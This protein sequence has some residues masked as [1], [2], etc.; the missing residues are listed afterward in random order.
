MPRRTATN[1]R[2]GNLAHINGAQ[3]TSMGALLFEGVLKGEPVDYRGQHAHV[4]RSGPID[5]ER[6]LARAPKDISSTHHDGDLHADVID[7][8]QL[9]GHSRY[10]L[11]IDA[12]TVRSLQRLPRKLQH[13]LRIR[14]TLGLE[15]WHHFVH[16]SCNGIL[17]CDFVQFSAGHFSRDAQRVAIGAALSH[18]SAKYWQATLSARAAAR[19]LQLF[20]RRHWLFHLL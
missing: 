18:G 2:F 15:R 17:R 11:R 5:G 16:F 12:G 7:L 4:I 9:C 8:F 14:R 1:E 13:D 3:H 20:P 19:P 10:G 6:F